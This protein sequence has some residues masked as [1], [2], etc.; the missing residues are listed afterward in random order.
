MS[1]KEDLL[2]I[3]TISFIAITNANGDPVLLPSN[4]PVNDA[5]DRSFNHYIP[6]I[7]ISDIPQTPLPSCSS[8]LYAEND[9]LINSY[10]DLIL[11]VNTYSEV[12]PRQV[13]WLL[14]FSFFYFFFS[15]SLL[16]S[17]I[18]VFLLFLSSLPSMYSIQAS[19]EIRAC[20]SHKV[21]CWNLNK[22]LCSVV[23]C[24]AV[25]ILTPNL[26]FGTLI[27]VVM[28]NYRLFT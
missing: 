11:P 15:L 22:T 9:V 1:D 6:N 26:I 8:E 4:G 21:F 16:I 28:M 3:G 14:L 27:L 20:K 25:M 12:V 5:G 2:T 24:P 19:L 23:N 17:L 13:S 10:I 18:N 7:A